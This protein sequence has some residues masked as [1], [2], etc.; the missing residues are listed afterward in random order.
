MQDWNLLS[1]NEWQTKERETAGEYGGYYNPYAAQYESWNQGISEER[2]SG[3]TTL[4]NQDEQYSG[5]EE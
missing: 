1:S 4:Q 3:Q 2:Y 5:Q